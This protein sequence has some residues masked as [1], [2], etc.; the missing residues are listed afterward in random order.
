MKVEGITV[1]GK[2][3]FEPKNK[4]ARMEILRKVLDK[5]SDDLKDVIELSLSEVGYDEIKKRINKS[6]ETLFN[7]IIK[8]DNFKFNEESDIISFDILLKDFINDC[9]NNIES[10]GYNG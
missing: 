10:D 9:Y 4:E 8:I 3:V 2:K 6:C 7:P 1:W 5:L